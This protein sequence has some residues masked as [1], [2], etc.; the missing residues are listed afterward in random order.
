[1][2]FEYM[3][4]KL[5]WLII[6]FIIFCY[7]LDWLK[8]KSEMLA[9]ILLEAAAVY[10]VHAASRTILTFTIVLLGAQ[11]GIACLWVVSEEIVG[12]IDDFIDRGS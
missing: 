12:E 6:A 4:W 1:M 8:Q 5:V 9:F 2:G 10:I 7:I 3:F 11:L